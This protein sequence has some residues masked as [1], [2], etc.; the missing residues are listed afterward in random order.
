MDQLSSGHQF[1]L[2]EDNISDVS[3]MLYNK[4]RKN[5]RKGR[6]LTLKK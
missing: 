3:F 4:E 6:W 5:L 2:A 1:L